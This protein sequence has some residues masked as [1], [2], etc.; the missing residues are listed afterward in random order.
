M[1]VKVVLGVAGVFTVE[2][3]GL[4]LLVVVPSAGLGKTDSAASSVIAVK[5]LFSIHFSSDVGG[6]VP[7]S[8]TQI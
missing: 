2:L 3:W 8:K 5:L 6:G 4:R 1:G 7:G